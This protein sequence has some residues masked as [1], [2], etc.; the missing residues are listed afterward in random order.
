MKHSVSAQNWCSFL[1]WRTEQWQNVNLVTWF[2]FFLFFFLKRWKYRKIHEKP[3]PLIDFIIILS[4]VRIETAYFWGR[5]W[6]LHCLL[7]TQMIGEIKGNCELW[8]ERKC[9]CYSKTRPNVPS[10]RWI[11][12]VESNEYVMAP[13]AK[14]TLGSRFNFSALYQRVVS[15]S[16][17]NLQMIHL[18]PRD[19]IICTISNMAIY[20]SI[21][22]VLRIQFQKIFHCTCVMRVCVYDHN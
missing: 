21:I 1:E 2:G 8:M 16:T 15:M 6:A 20:Y 3:E 11:C 9:T 7:R 10:S 5:I 4:T 19:D 22:V 14:G 18:L 12:N 17:C 13:D